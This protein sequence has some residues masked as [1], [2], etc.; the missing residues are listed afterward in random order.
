MN[1]QSRKTNSTDSLLLPPREEP[2]ILTDVLEKQVQGCRDELV[3]NLRDSFL[4]F[5]VDNETDTMMSEFQPSPFRVTKDYASI[6]PTRPWRQYVGKEC[7]WTWFGWNQQGYL[8][9]VLIS[10]DG[11]EPS[12]L[13]QTIASSIKVFTIAPVEETPPSAKSRESKTKARGKR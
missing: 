10:F 11:I 4:R 8:D 12:I 13:L 7:G 6:Q 2:Y 5:V 9:M 1:S 3:L